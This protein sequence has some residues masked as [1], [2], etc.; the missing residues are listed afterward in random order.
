LKDPAV[1]IPSLAARWEHVH[2]LPHALD[3]VGV[4]KMALVQQNVM[5]HARERTQRQ[6]GQLS[7]VRCPLSC[8]GVRN[9][10][11]EGLEKLKYNNVFLNLFFNYQ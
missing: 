3:E 7:R 4:D 10:I 8:H 1:V 9:V 5:P 6:L 11:R 2:K